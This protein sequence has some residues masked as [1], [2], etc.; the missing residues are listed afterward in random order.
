VELRDLLYFATVAQQQSFTRAAEKLGI[1]QS[2]ISQQIKT[3]EE[4]LEVQLLVRT[5]RSVRL[6]AAGQAFLRE[7]KDIINRVE[8]SR[9]EARRAAQGETGALSIGFFK[10]GSFLFLPELIHAYRTHYPSV[11]IDLHEQ[12]PSEQLDSLELG[13]IDVG[14][15][16]PLPKAQ[17]ARFVQERVYRD[18]VVAVLPYRHALACSRKISLEKLA[19]ENWV[20]LSRSTAPELV[21]GFMLLCTN[22]GF[23]PRV[24][25]QP[26]RMQAALTMVAAGIGVSLAPSSV[27]SFYQPGVALIPIQP[28]PP[29][30]DLV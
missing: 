4:E 14:F 20:L 7:A 25:N 21:D 8:Q 22:A 28:D 29:P 6:T 24:I 15:T 13:R 18:R 11:R 10:T 9:V 17:A 27:R 5:K 16:R 26:A 23:W 1:A 12:T 30:L 19:N 2:A 3:L